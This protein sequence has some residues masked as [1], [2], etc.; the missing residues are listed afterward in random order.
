MMAWEAVRLF[1]GG[2][3]V[4]A[5]AAGLF[6]GTV[7][8][9]VAVFGGVP[10]VVP[11]PALPSSAA[12]VPGG[13]LAPPPHRR[14][15]RSPHAQPAPVSAIPVPVRTRHPARTHAP[16]PAPSTPRPTESVPPASTPAPTPPGVISGSGT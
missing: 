13:H 14:P 2:V 11:S 12:A 6:W 10:A 7:T 1:A 16:A 9:L 3:V 15:L 5:A 4:L 8:V